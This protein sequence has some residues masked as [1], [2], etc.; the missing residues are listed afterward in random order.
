MGT[1]RVPHFGYPLINFNDND[2]GNN[3]P[4]IANMLL[5]KAGSKRKG[6]S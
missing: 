4:N 2:K 1:G 6:T 5:G 3:R